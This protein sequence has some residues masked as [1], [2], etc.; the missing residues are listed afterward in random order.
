LS[1]V[2]PRDFASD[3]DIGFVSFG[4]FTL[5]TNFR[6]GFLHSGQTSRGARSTGRINSK[7]R[8]QIRQDCSGSS[9]MYS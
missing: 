3:T 9:A 5:E 6:T 4:E 1:T 8:A 7:P 2:S